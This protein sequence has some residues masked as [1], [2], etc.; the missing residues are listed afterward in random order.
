[1]NQRKSDIR[2]R[3]LDRRDALAPAERRRLSADITARILSLPACGRAQT[4][5]AYSSFG[6]EFSTGAFIDA[7]LESGSTLVLPRVNRGTRQL[8]LYRVSNPKRELVPGTWGIAEPDPHVCPPVSP[9]LVDMVLVP[10]VA[11]DRSGARIG[12]GAG[13]YD[14]LLVSCLALGGRPRTVAPTFGCQIVDAVPIEPHDVLVDHVV[15]ESDCFPTP[16]G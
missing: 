13:Y 2:A 7:V 15:T 6:S 3:V 14:K 12:Y 9:A 16:G 11:F 4:V 8:D 10:G 5:L 1:M